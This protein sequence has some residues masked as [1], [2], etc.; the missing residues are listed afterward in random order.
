MD[1]IENIWIYNSADRSFHYGS[2]SYDERFEEVSC[3]ASSV[4]SGKGECVIPGLVDC[5]MHIESSML[6]PSSFSHVAAKHGTTTMIS[7]CHEISNVAG[8]PGLKEFMH[9]KTVNH[10]FYAIPSSVPASS[11]E[12]ETTGGV[13]DAAEVRALSGEKDI[14]CLGEVMNAKDLF[15]EGDNRTKRMIREFVRC[16]PHCPVEGHIARL[17]GRELDR[18]LSYGVSSDHT[19]QTVSSLLEKLSKGVFIQL[20][21]KAI[22]EEIISVLDGVYDGH[23]SLVTD[24]VLPDTLVY[25]G[26]LDRVVRKA[27]ASGLSPE[28]AVYAATYAPC[29]HMHLDDRGMIAPGKLADFII[30]EDLESFS[31]KEVYISGSCVYRKGEGML[32][33]V[34]ETTLSSGCSSSIRRSEVKAEEFSLKAY[35]S[36]VQTITAIGHQEGSTMTLRRSVEVEVGPSLELP[37]E[38]I[39]ILASVER[40]GH[41]APVIPVPLVDGLSKEGAIASSWAH[42]SHNILVLATS[43][44]LAA[45]AVNEVIRL[46]GGIVCVDSTSLI[47]VP[48]GYGGIVSLEDPEDLAFGISAVRSWLREHG[49]KAI[50]EIMSFAVLGLPVSPEVK[51]T[52]KGLVDV[53]EKKIIDWRER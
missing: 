7:D 48:L 11:A 37:L 17:S 25:D 20:Q 36:G 12:L 5:H 52:D 35:R 39:N 22:T 32:V 34:P 29:N 9:Q 44:E 45:E 1:R 38:K 14:I 50:D 21:Y 28:R 3:E 49:Y 47:K 41:N 4:F 51:V 18:F 42:D 27:I 16:F 2:F 31:I 6:P 24:D 53:K 33:P 30:L 15:S 19:E 46:Q 13:F 10:A 26:Q 8:V 43:P 23:F 40:Y